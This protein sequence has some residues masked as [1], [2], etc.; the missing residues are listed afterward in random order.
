MRHHFNLLHLLCLAAWFLF[1]VSCGDSAPASNSSKEVDNTTVSNEANSEETTTTAPEPAPNAVIAEKQVGDF[2]IGQPMPEGG[3]AVSK[4]MQTIQSEGA[5]EEV[6]VYM[7]KD[8]ETVLLE[9][10]PAYD[11]TGEGY[12]DQPGDILVQDARFKT[13]ENVGVGSTI[14]ELMTAYGDVDLWY[15][16]VS[17]AYVAQPKSLNGVQ[18]LIDPEAYVGTGD[19]SSSDRVNLT[20]DDF[21]ASAPIVSVRVY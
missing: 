10:S 21:K 17:G 16:Y 12:T 13:A 4:E 5:S 9:I 11:M 15:T 20:K 2:A 7:V 8:G 14:E 1:V 19:L 18:F 3:Y 6:P